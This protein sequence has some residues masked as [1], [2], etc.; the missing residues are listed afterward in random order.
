MIKAH[1]NICDR[2]VERYGPEG[3]MIVVSSLNNVVLYIRPMFKKKDSEKELKTT[4]QV[5]GK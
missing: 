4:L 5:L 1:C 3:S 2:T